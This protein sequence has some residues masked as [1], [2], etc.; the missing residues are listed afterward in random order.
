MII[1][2]DFDGTLCE[3]KFPKIGE[4]IKGV[5]EK[6]ITLKK[7]GTQIIL[8]TCREGQPLQE[9]IW[10][11]RMKGLE[12][13]AVNENVSSQKNKE[14]GIRKIYADM[15]LDDRNETIREFIK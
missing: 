4:P 10:W 7:D 6:L 9:A 12:F 8:W 2:V 1:A 15:Y 5:L 3:H 13:D 11:C 14:Y